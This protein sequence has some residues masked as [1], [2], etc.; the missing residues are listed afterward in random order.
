MGLVLFLTCLCIYIFSINFSPIKQI[1]KDVKV[2]TDCEKYIVVEPL[3]K[4]LNCNKKFLYLKINLE[5][6]A[7]SKDRKFK[8]LVFKRFY[9]DI[10]KISLFDN[11]FSVYLEDGKLFEFKVPRMQI[12]DLTGIM[13]NLQKY[14]DII[15]AEL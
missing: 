2:I 11:I 6:L 3:D 12:K 7:I 4:L 9:E 8:E 5:Y 15:N 1:Y 13:E 10:T 14:K